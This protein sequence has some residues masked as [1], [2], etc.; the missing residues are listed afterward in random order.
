MIKK[1]YIILILI[2]PSFLSFSQHWEA[3]GLIGGLQNEEVSSIATDNDGYLYVTGIFSGESYIGNDTLHAHG[4]RDIFIAKYNNVNDPIWVKQIMGP[5][6][7]NLLFSKIIGFDNAN[8]VY[9]AGYFFGEITLGNTTYISGG[10]TDIFIAKFSSNG[11]YIW[12][13][14]EGSSK[15]EG[16]TSGSVDNSGNI[17]LAG[18]FYDF[19]SFGNYLLFGAGS[20]DI[21]LVKY[22]NMGHIMWA[23]AEG[24]NSIDN[25]TDMTTGPGNNIYLT[26]YFSASITFRDTT[27][28]SNGG[29]DI[30]LVKY[31]PF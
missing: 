28:Y 8:N 13:R 20:R 14:H 3:A 18:F 1:L 30:F 25:V 15:Y 10:G 7:N 23:K 2:F 21:F 12:S 22:N 31:N 16:V 19:I 4:I 24:G 26:G 9:I 5:N 11:D 17:V 6:V 27:I 29:I